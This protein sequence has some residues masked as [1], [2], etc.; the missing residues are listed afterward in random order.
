V[1]LI[2]NKCVCRRHMDSASATA[3]ATAA[4]GVKYDVVEIRVCANE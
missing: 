1:F 2:S 4:S 3:A